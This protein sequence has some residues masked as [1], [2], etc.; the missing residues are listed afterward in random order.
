MEPEYTH[1]DGHFTNYSQNRDP[2]GWQFWTHPSDTERN[3][4]S[5]IRIPA[6]LRATEIVP[7]SVEPLKEADDD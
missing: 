2:S 4:R 6:E 7:V 5:K 1:L 3:Y